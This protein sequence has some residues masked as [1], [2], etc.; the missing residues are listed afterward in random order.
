MICYVIL[1][2][3]N[4]GDTLKCLKSL[5]ETA[6]PDSRFIVVDNGSGD[7]SGEKLAAL[8]AGDEQCDVLLLPENVGFSK[9][10]NAGYRRAKERYAPEFIVVTNNDV[11]FYQKDFEDKIRALFARTRFYVLGP[12]IYIPRHKDHQSPLF[13]RGITV[14]A[15]KRELEEYRFYRENPQKFERRLRMHAFKDML[16]SQSGIIRSVYAKLR[17]KDDLDYR[18]EY[19]NVGLQG[20]CLIYSALFIDREDKAFAPEPF[21]YEEEVFLFYS[22]QSKGYKMVYSPEIGIRHEEGASFTNANKNNEARLRFMLEHH[23]KAREMLL[24]YL[25][26]REKQSK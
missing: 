8:Y 7:G 20:S 25:V 3:K 11:V 22:C 23:V 12:D 26:N 13:K 4:I 21:L 16:C 1:H 9:G 14:E 6:A 5:K 15:L 17:G 18:R 24:E 2:Y 19:E 10:N